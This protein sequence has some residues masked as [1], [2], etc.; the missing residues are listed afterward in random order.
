MIKKIWLCVLP[1]LVIL[2]ASCS[3]PNESEKN[4]GPPVI[5]QTSVSD[6]L[7]ILD[8]NVTAVIWA[9]VQ[10]PDGPE[11]ISSVQYYLRLP[12]GTPAYGGSP[13]ELF[14]NG[15]QGDDSAG[16]GI[17]SSQIIFTNTALP[18]IYV[19]TFQAEDKAGGL[20]ENAVDSMRLHKE[21]E[22][23][24]LGPAR[25]V[26]TDLPDSLQI[27]GL[28]AEALVKALVEDPDGLQDIESVYFYSRKPDGTMAN[29]GNPIYMFDDASSGDET[30][31]DGIYSTGIL[32]T[33]SSQSGRYV[34]TFYALDK[35]GHLSD[36]ETDSIEVYE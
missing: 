28:T 9:Q 26:S 3:S 7:Q 19:F 16:D 35:V 15:S 14:D 10:D 4:E 34:F 21:A 20:S 29:G 30:A 36:A 8:E 12:D 24:D 25:I 32:I 18:G 5:T 27:P 22:E 33:N 17:F 13:G 2:T 31:N 1:I 23:P 11:N 6:S